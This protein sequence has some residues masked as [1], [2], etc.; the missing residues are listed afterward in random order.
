MNL[1]RLLSLLRSGALYCCRLD[2]FKDPWEGL[3]PRR[4]LDA[5]NERA[6]ASLPGSIYPGDDFWKQRDFMFA[7]CWHENMHESAA[8]WDQYGRSGIAIRSTI[9]RLKEAGHSDLPFHIGRVKYLDFERERP[10]MKELNALVSPFLK[11]KSFEHEREVR[12]LV[13][14]FPNYQRGTEYTVQSQTIPVTL[15][16][17]VEAVFLSPTCPEWFVADMQELLRRFGLNV[18]VQ[19]SNLYDPRVS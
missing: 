11:R 12:V 2:K 7:N 18:T 8:L 1:E 3:W 16:I 17:L 5:I 6:E 9:G 13:W 14:D 19:R 10:N 15:K 4:V